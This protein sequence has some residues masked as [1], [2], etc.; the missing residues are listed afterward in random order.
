MGDYNKDYP[1][2]IDPLLASTFI[3]GSNWD[4]V[5]S[6]AIDGSGNVYVT[7]NTRSSDYPTTTGAYDESY[8]DGYI[9][10]FVSKFDSTLSSLSSSTFI[11]GGDDDRAY[12]ITIDGSDVYITGVTKSYNYPITDGAYDESYNGSGD[13]FYLKV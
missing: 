13:V 12:S 9:D 10:V 11:G 1:L 2:I 8:N 3:G 7:G 6:I 5:F 4:L